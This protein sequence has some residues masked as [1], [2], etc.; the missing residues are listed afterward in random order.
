[1]HARKQRGCSDISPS[2]K[3][4][5]CD[6]DTAALM[7]RDTKCDGAVLAFMYVM[8]SVNVNLCWFALLYT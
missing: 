1:M 7:N 5:L 4:K 8:T 3:C 2:R 6:R